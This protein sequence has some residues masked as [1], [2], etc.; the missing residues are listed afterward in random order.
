MREGTR[1]L[2]GAAEAVAALKTA[3][4]LVGVCSNKPRV[5]TAELLAFLGLKVDAT[6]GPEDVARPKPAPDMLTLALARLGV[7]P[8]EAL[9]VG[10]MAVDVQT[11]RAAGVRVW[12]VPTGSDDLGTLERAGADGLFRT[13][14]ELPRLLGVTSA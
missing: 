4:L 13:L 3:E 14:H 11:A 8:G 1:L 12:V 10:D 5:F 9:Y 7:A 2:P 6:V